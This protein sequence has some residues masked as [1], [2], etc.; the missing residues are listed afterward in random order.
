MANVYAAGPQ[1]WNGHPEQTHEQD[2]QPNWGS[3]D[4]SSEMA[5]PGAGPVFFNPSQFSG[6]I[7]S[8]RRNKYA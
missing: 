6:P 2:L 3:A 1:D 7:P 5:T 8:T 4:A